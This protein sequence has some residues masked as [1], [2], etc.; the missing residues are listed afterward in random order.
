[1]TPATPAEWIEIVWKVGGVVVVCAGAYFAIKQGVRD[2]MRVAGE[3]KTQ[4]G[5]AKDAAAEAVSVAEKAVDT[6]MAAFRQ[7]MERFEQRTDQ[8]DEALRKRLEDQDRRI[9]VMERVQ[10]L[11][12]QD[13]KAGI[14]RIELSIAGMRTY[15]E[16]AI[17]KVHERIDE[18]FRPRP[19]GQA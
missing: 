18:H 15:M 7:F 8:R 6:T 2:A 19:G 1:M 14:A 17:S 4:A 11:R 9:A 5:E 12:D 13:T 16:G 3:A 10:E